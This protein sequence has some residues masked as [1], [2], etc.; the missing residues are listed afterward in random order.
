[1]A[2]VAGLASLADHA[3]LREVLDLNAQ[4]RPRLATG[5]RELG[6]EPIESVAN[7]L[8][9]PLGSAERVG[10]LSEA[11]LRRGLI[12]RPLGPFGFPEA[13]RITTGT[14]EQVTLLLDNMAEV[15]ED[16]RGGGW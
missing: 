15:L 3:R 11:L 2:L 9:V 1:M 13:I 8:M 16:L 5:L 10:A 4:E 7:F 14:T 6:L 12:V